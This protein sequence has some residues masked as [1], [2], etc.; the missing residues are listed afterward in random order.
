MEF[1]S[2]PVFPLEQSV[3][4]SLLGFHANQR[5]QL[6]VDWVPPTLKAP[7]NQQLPRAPYH[8]DGSAAVGE[9]FIF[10]VTVPDYSPHIYRGYSMHVPLDC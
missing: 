3:R 6:A 8:R 9:W 4:P 7:A 1:K 2:L 5:Y 10:T